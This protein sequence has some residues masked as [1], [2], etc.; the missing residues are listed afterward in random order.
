MFVLKLTKSVRFPTSA[1]ISL[2]KL[3]FVDTFAPNNAMVLIAADRN[4]GI[5]LVVV[6]V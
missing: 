1:V 4:V 2:Q 5:I 6:M 3:C